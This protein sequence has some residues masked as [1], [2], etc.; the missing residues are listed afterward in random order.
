MDNHGII[1]IKPNKHYDYDYDSDEA[2]ETPNTIDSE[3]TGSGQD[4]DDIDWLPSSEHR[5]MTTMPL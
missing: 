2:S 5:V 4:A 3:L 1:N